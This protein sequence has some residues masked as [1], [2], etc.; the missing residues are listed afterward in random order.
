MALIFQGLFRIWPSDNISP[1]KWAS[2][3]K[4]H[5]LFAC[6]WNPYYYKL[7][8]THIYHQAVCL[9]PSREVD[10]HLFT[11]IVSIYVLLTFLYLPYECNMPSRI[12]MA[13][14]VLAKNADVCYYS[15][16]FLS[17]RRERY[18]PEAIKEV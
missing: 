5:D 1:Q 12:I 4:K 11:E 7:L 9:R 16:Y 6:A 13:L 10:S 17:R 15:N 8:K 14:F 3:A 18:L 2:K